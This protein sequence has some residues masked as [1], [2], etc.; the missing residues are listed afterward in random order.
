MKEILW[1]WNFGGRWWLPGG[2]GETEELI[3]R[4]GGGEETASMT[5]DEKLKPSPRLTTKM[6]VHI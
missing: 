5:E 2:L 6:Y 1:Q 3:S 4:E